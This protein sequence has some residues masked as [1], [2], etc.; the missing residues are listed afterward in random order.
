MK[1]W[2]EIFYCLAIP[3]CKE[4]SEE[5]KRE[6]LEELRSV[7]TDMFDCNE[8]SDEIMAWTGNCGT[9]D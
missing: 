1:T 9:T 2:N 6:E 3:D 7:F 8:V 4:I 5:V